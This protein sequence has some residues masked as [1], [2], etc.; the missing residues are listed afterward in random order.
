MGQRVR[1][2]G[3]I[4]LAMAL[5]LVLPA[6]G[7]YAQYENGSLVGTI[8]DSSG[9]SIPNVNVMVTNNSTGIVSNVT[10][11][12][13][14]DYE[15][16]SL[17]FGIYTIA[18]RAAGFADAVAKDITISV[19]GR[20][21]ID[22]VLTIGSAQTTV[23]VTGVALQLET[24][25]SQRGQTVTEYQ[26]EALPLVTRNYSDLVDY[27]TGAR[28][29]PAD[30]TTTS[31]TSL[32][33]AGSFN[34][35]GQRSMFN[36]FMLD[37]MD[38]NAYGESN[39]GFDNQIIA[40]P[41]DSIAQ[42]EVVTNNESAEYGRSS[43]AT[44]NVATKSGT[45]QFHT[46]LY[47]FIRNTDLNAFGYIKPVT[48][49]AAGVQYPFFKPEF[50]RN[51][52]GADFGGPIMKNKFF[53]FLDYEGFRQTLT[54]TVVDTVPTT[55]ELNGQL[56]VAVQDPWH[57]G[58][59]IPAGTPY[60]NWPG[61]AKADAD[62]T[63]LKIA[64]L[65]AT[66]LPGKCTAASGLA[67]TGVDTNNCPLNAPFTDHAD[68]GDLRLDYQQS[69]NTSWFVKVSDRKETGKNFN[70]LPEPIDMQSNGEILIHD[71]Q[72]S[73]GYNHLMGDNKVVDARLALSGTEA[74]KWTYAIGSS[75]FPAGSIPGLPT[76]AGVS[77]GLPSMAISGGFTSFGRQSTNPQWQNPSVLNPKV[78]YSW[79]KGKHSFKFGYEYEY[80]WMEVEDSNPLYGSFTFNH[81]YSVCPAS[82]GATNC[83]NGTSAV[84]DTY[85]ADFLFGAS[86]Q[87]SLS[88]YYIAHLHQNME[89][90]YAQDDWKVAPKLTLN[91]GVRWEY[92]SPYSERNDNLSNFNPATG[93]MLTLDPGFAAMS[94][95][96]QPVTGYPNIEPGMIS[97]YNGGGVYGKTLVHPALNDYAPRIGFAYALTPSVAVHGGYGTSFIHYWRAGSGN[98]LGI[99]APNAMFTS[100]INP[101]PAT[102]VGLGATTGYQRLSNGFPTGL[103][104][105][106]S[107]G[108][109]NIDYIPQNT[110]DGYAESYFLSVQKTLAKNILV[111]IAYVGN[112][113]V[114]LQG[115]INANQRNPSLPLTTA[116]EFPGVPA[117]QWQRPYMAWGGT[118]LNNPANSFNN[119]DIT[120]ASN[121]FHS[122]YNSL[123]ARYE[124]R[125]VAGLTLLN[126]FTWSHAL[127]NASSTL[128][129]NTPDPQD[130]N[131]LNADYGQSDY[132][133]PI[134]NVTSF[135]YDLP[136]G[137]GKRFLAS[138][139]ALENVLFGGWQISGINTVQGGTPFNLTYT[140]A[141]ANQVS[142]MLTQNWRGESLYR[143]NL[144][145]GAHYTQGKIK[146]ANGYIQYVNPNALTIPSTYTTGSSLG[147]G[148]TISSPFGSLPKNFGRTMPFYETDLDLNKKFNTPIERV[149]VEFRSELYNI[150]NHTNLY[151]PGG[152][153]GGTVSGTDNN[154]SAPT[155]TGGG[156]M[157]G[158]FEPRIVQF[159][160]KIIY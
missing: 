33:R 20:V 11:N 106:F 63:A 149:K 123:Q 158:T 81:G 76:I 61:Q 70:L 26:S 126:S 59:Y 28:P 122:H 66:A 154:I 43:G 46:T 5:L 115:F 111:D 75:T 80:I 131:N 99:N 48:L 117:G 77:G 39:Q 21:R 64:G 10:T 73:L 89:S 15:V 114:H 1:I 97:S 30:A 85:W 134:A 53:F 17:R 160:L 67:T 118:L 143:P 3:W 147:A 50:D 13:A 65:Y 145:P 44:I 150:F 155:S 23:E 87:Y 153:G 108:T 8:H 68:K 41:P 47:E 105:V 60:A 19:G 51:Q 142:P 71:R 38:N 79:V 100:V 90:G 72:V 141:S 52:F 136:V 121:G 93:T 86:G 54:P 25:S 146:L 78:N 37:G 104:T 128:E 137:Q 62:V 119:G 113:G 140:P 45:N 2:S 55:N 49:N 31:V 32:T 29:A 35:N 95:G 40:P 112:H 120:E 74:G 96:V 22:L 16:P 98:M 101:S 129:A 9:A 159:G 132:N 130:G 107:A 27:V 42:F 6:L 12:A 139:N 57:P 94:T 148:G 91:L 124:Q 127:D 133:L 103:A 36:N 83:P 152:S 151:L 24:E 156:Q 84:A 102:G 34:V 157:T 109:D 7:A 125:F 56:A 92:G 58:T 88:T 4:R 138:S 110:K 18:A 144:V 69:Q 116:G 135:V 82:A 14:G